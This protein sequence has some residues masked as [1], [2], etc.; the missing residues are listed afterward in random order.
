ML[1]KEKREELLYKTGLPE[2]LVDY[3]DCLKLTD[4]AD[5]LIDLWVA[6]EELTKEEAKE[7]LDYVT[8]Q[9]I[10]F[11][12]N[13]SHKTFKNPNKTIPLLEK[14]YKLNES[15]SEVKCLWL[16]IIIKYSYE[17][18]YHVIKDFLL[19]IGRGKFVFPLHRE[20][21]QNP[22]LLIIILVKQKI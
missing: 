19:N 21:N 14:Y 20:M 13:L 6:K 9:K 2:Y 4:E 15:N 11:I 12:E 18:Y 10:Y 1:S 5:K 3:S 16:S 22:Y 8:Y 17:E 7:Y